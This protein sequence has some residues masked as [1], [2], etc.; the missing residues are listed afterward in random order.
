MNFYRNIII[1]TLLLSIVSIEG[2]QAQYTKKALN[3]R[4]SRFGIKI[5]GGI[6]SLRPE[7]VHLG[8]SD[9][10]VIHSIALEKTQPQS[11]FGVFAYR[12]IGWLYGDFSAMYA[13]HGMIFEVTSY[14]E[15]NT[16]T[17]TL[18]EQFGYLD[19]QV[20]GGL[21]LNGFRI[22]VGPVMHILGY[23]DSDLNTLDNYV[24]K[25]RSVSFGFSG[26]IGYEI[27]RVALEFK[28]DKAFRTI[29]DHIYS[30]TRKSHFLETPDAF[31]LLLSITLFKP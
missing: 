22:G 13:R 28:F 5:M 18:A 15:E 24:Q 12:K 14:S 29:G 3:Y 27:E 1:A 11:S 6:I 2:I 25:L 7:V 4:Q 19:L 23:H 31:S 10:V 20:M 9:D 16:P 30:G 26:S 8:K 17:R 21:T